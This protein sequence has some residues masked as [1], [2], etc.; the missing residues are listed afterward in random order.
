M[1][2]RNI[3]ER[4]HIDAVPSKENHRTRKLLR[5]V[6]QLSD[7]ILLFRDLDQ[8]CHFVLIGGRQILQPIDALI[9]IGQRQEIQQRVEWRQYPGWEPVANEI[10]PQ[11]RKGQSLGAA[12]RDIRVSKQ[13]VGSP[14][15]GQE[16]NRLSS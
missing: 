2:R 9:D 16:Q 13:S 14:R 7:E 5:P 11:C 8:A 1:E 3:Q 15:E 12:D 10:T 4:V 6:L